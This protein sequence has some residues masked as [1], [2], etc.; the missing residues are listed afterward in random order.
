MEGGGGG[1]AQKK[2]EFT[3][4]RY[5]EYKFINIM[6]NYPMN[7]KFTIILH[8]YIFIIFNYYKYRHGILTL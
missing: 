6:L 4:R 3:H 8:Y 5:A 2:A 7:L 1:G